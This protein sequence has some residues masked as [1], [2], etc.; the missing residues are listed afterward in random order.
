MIGDIHAEAQF[1]ETALAFLSTLDL[2]A[3]LSVGDIVDGRG[4]VDRC[5]ELLAQHR[6]ITIR[7]NHDRWFLNGEMRN[8]SDAT[9]IDEV[10]TQS[11]RFIAGLL[12]MQTFQTVPGNLLLCHGIAEHDMVRVTPDDFGYAIESNFELQD[13]IRFKRFRYVING[14]THRRMVRTFGET[15]IINGGTLKHDE[16]PCF[17]TV[18]FAS[19]VAQLYEIQE[20]L[21]VADNERMQI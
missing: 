15:V 8:M 7:G 6:V 5:C 12:P 1:L 18:D 13:L 11:R 19:K 10:N 9:Q 4:S 16:A 3:I 14:H 17:L 20:N 2:D 21:G